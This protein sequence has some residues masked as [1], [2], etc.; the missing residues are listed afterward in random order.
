MQDGP[1]ILSYRPA[2]WNS[3]SFGTS[4]T[5]S[6]ARFAEV[7]TKLRQVVDP[8]PCVDLCE[9]WEALADT[10]D[11]RKKF[12]DT[13]GSTI[14]MIVENGLVIEACSLDVLDTAVRN[15]EN[16]VE[17]LMTKMQTYQAGSISARDMLCFAHSWSTQ[18]ALAVIN[19]HLATTRCLILAMRAQ[20]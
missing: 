9:A 20:K 13:V 6:K 18:Y 14:S 1:V 3:V 19:C 8:V 16:K 15:M 7:V 11:S 5:A 2:P 10:V 17:S 4:L 12:M